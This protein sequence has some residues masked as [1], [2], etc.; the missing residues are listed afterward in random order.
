MGTSV[1]ANG[2]SILHK[3]HGKTH[4]SAV[5]DVCK[6]PSPGGPIPI[7]YPNMAMD[8]NLADGAAT[9]Q[10]EGNPVANVKSKISTSSGDEP[11]S[12]GGL[13]SNVNKGTCTWKMGSP[14]VKAEGES[15]VRFLDTTFHNGNSFNTSFLGQGGVGMGYGDDFDGKCPVCGKEPPEHAIASTGSTAAL[16]AELVKQ[17]VSAFE[18]GNKKVAKGSKDNPTGYMVGVMVCRHATNKDRDKSSTFAAM[19]GNTLPAFM[20]VVNSWG[21][22]TPIGGKI[23]Q[24]EELISANTS[25]AS[26][27]T[28]TTNVMS[29]FALVTYLDL[30]PN[31]LMK[32]LGYTGYGSCAASKLL[33]RSKHGP[34][35]MTEAYFNPPT[36][37]TPPTLGPYWMRR[38]GIRIGQAT[39]EA[40]TREMP[41]CN[42]CQATLFMTMCPVRQCV[43]SA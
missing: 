42:T 8:S 27:A 11:G 18:G 17:L 40:D 24:P 33:A 10:I 5:P 23:V 22:A 13:M 39:W 21:E 30:Q 2:R 15:V 32:K 4:A 31:K 26:V 19:S 6:T 25:T 9:V 28:V 16:C 43:A 35:Q 7:P 20:E 1:D 3:G 36:N 34:I 12:V 38:N 29:R 41:S 37:T 14:D